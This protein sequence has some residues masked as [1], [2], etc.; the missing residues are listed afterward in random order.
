[1]GFLK[2]RDCTCAHLVGMGL[3]LI[4]YYDEQLFTIAN[5]HA[6]IRLI[7]TILDKRALLGGG[8]IRK[9]RRMNDDS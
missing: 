8:V 5:F 4:K 3:R 1:L 2:I 6:D 9:P 7:M